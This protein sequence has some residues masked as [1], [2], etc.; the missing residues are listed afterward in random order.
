MH[1]WPKLPPFSGFHP[2]FVTG[3]PQASARPTRTNFN[4]GVHEATAVAITLAFAI[5]AAAAAV[6]VVIAAVIATA[7]SALV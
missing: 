4:H 1:F 3:H 5:A 7:A 2:K 6:L